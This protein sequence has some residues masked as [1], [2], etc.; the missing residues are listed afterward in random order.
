MDVL[1]IQSQRIGHN[2]EAGKTHGGGTDHGVGKSKHCQGDADAV[3]K[4]GPKEVFVNI[5]KCCTTQT[6]CCRYA[7]YDGI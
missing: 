3:V 1:E 4:E 7:N 2:A 6:Y 5:L